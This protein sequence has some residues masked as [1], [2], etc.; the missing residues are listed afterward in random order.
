VPEAA[1]SAGAAA[2]DPG[3]VAW[4]MIRPRGHSRAAGRRGGLHGRGVGIEAVDCCACMPHRPYVYRVRSCDAEGAARRGWAARHMIAEDARWGADVVLSCQRVPAMA[5]YI[6]FILGHHLVRIAY[7]GS[8]AL[9]SSDPTT[10]IPTLA[11][12]LRGRFSAITE[13][14]RHT[15]KTLDDSSANY[16]SIIAA[17]ES[18]MRDQHD[19]F[20]GRA[21]RWLRWLE[22]DLG[23]YSC[24]G[25][26]VGST[27]S[28]AFRL[29]YGFDESA[30]LSTEGPRELFEEWG[31]TFSV[32]CAAS[33]D[34]APP[35]ATI[36]FAR[37]ARIR[38]VDRL[39]SKY[40]AKRY[41]E[42]FSSGL[43]LLILMIEG[44]LNASRLLLPL[45]APGHEIAVFRAQVVTLYHSL[46]G[47]RKIMDQCLIK[48]TPGVR[49][50]STLLDDAPTKRLMSHQ[51][52]KVRDR[53]VHYQI[54]NPTFNPDPS[55]P[56]YG[57]VEREYPGSSWEKYYSDIRS[58]TDRVTECLES[59]N[60]E[61]ARQTDS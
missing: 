25:G 38:P 19:R 18:I 46:T 14:I 5:N 29:G 21:H 13:R 6:P 30:K 28:A 51:G 34:T 32:L 55:L 44:D 57:I 40:L 41:E 56:M 4:I 43:K 50:L 53:C 11:A 23:L 58:M 31:A 36:K 26:L 37:R 27:I 39:A 61:A 8:F 49:S 22:K 1:R 47:L 2:L 24:E 3:G 20:T 35:A 33:L 15:S 59:W 60:S 16:G 7:E 42:G 54:R 17:F 9:R 48:A 12:L 10:G 52:K 45:T